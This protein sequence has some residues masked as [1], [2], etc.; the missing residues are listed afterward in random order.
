MV[1]G[2]RGHQDVQQSNAAAERAVMG[3]RIQ[4]LHDKLP[5]MLKELT[6]LQA[7]HKATQCVNNLLMRLAQ[8]MVQTPLHHLPVEQWMQYLNHATSFVAEGMFA[9]TTLLGEAAG[10]DY[11]TVAGAREAVLR[12]HHKVKTLWD[13][14][15]FGPGR[16]QSTPVL[17]SNMQPG[18]SAQRAL[19]PTQEETT[20]LLTQ[21][22]RLCVSLA[23]DSTTLQQV[24]EAKFQGVQAAQAELV[25]LTQEAAQ[26]QVPDDTAKSGI[27]TKGLTDPSTAYGKKVRQAVKNIT[28]QQNLEALYSAKQFPDFIQGTS[29]NENWHSFLRRYVKVQGGSRSLSLLEMFL[30]R[31]RMYYNLAVSQNKNSKGSSRKDKDGQLLNLRT[32]V[33]GVLL[34]EGLPL[35]TPIRRAWRDDMLVRHTVEDMEQLGFRPKRGFGESSKDWTA[36][37][38]QKLHQGMVRL[39]QEQEQIHTRDP[40]YWV[41]HYILEDRYSVR[42]VKGMLLTLRNMLHK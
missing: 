39:V 31:T 36:E 14:L 21:A 24:I 17:G 25:T 34:Q 15:R 41:A 2:V 40:Y 19:P 38:L 4:Q 26:Q 23:A 10:V 20:A 42:A 8:S 5:L 37:D 3:S 29:P 6:T 7:I 12:V 18:P 32:M 13:D 22:M 35:Q 27:Y 11:S 33:A 9:V 28:E 1:A 16:A 30:E